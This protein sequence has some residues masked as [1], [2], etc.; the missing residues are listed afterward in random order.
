M[1]KYIIIVAILLQANT[2]IAE[3]NTETS[4]ILYG[5]ATRSCGQFLKSY[6][7]QNEDYGFYVAW[8]QGYLSAINLYSVHDRRDIG[9][10]TDV[11]SM[12]LWLKNH[13]LQNPLNDFALSVLDLTNELKK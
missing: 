5:V 11:A 13:C 9:R 12:M 2:V 4:L 10:A 6:E 1:R 8:L 7:L 3:N